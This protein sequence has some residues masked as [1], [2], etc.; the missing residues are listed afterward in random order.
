M[1]NRSDLPLSETADL[2]RLV[3]HLPGMA[4]QILADNQRTLTFAS[5]GC[6]AL[7]GYVPEQLLFNKEL[8]FGALIHPHDLQMVVQDLAVAVEAKRPYQLVYRLLTKAKAEKWVL[9]RGTPIFAADGT[10]EMIEGLIT[11]HDKRVLDFQQLE[12]RVADRTRKLSALYDILEVAAD[13]SD[14]QTTINRT[15]RRV[16][17]AIKGNVGAI[18]LIDASGKQLKLAAQ[19]N[20]V[21]AVTTKINTITVE[22]SELAGWIFRQNRPLIIPSMSEDSRTVDFVGDDSLDVY[23][24]VPIVAQ[25]QVRGV[26]TV[27]SEDMTGYAAKEEVELLVSVGEQIGVVVENARLRTSAEQLVILEERNRLARELHDSV[28]QSLYSVTLF[29]E[30]GRTLA[31]AGNL[32]KATDYFE[33]VLSTGF[34]ALREMRLLV[35]KLRPDVLEQVGIVRALEHRLNAVEGRAGVKHQL[36]VHGEIE[37]QPELEEA[38]YQITQEALNNSLK[39]SGATEIEVVLRQNQK[40]IVLLVSDNG[41]GFDVKTAVSSGGFG[42]TSMRERVNLFHGEIIVESE[43]GM[44]TAVKARVPLST[45]LPMSEALK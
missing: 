30:A 17:K 43:L 6:L 23:I 34:Q 28:T 11:D 44:G 22:K 10:L 4:F 14:L 41:C 18:H 45:P 27:L 40:S 37:L 8:A 15:L 2:A 32:E 42:L 33:D 12:Q 9:E 29:A 25:E 24:G 3:N 5:Q 21:T 38:L 19:Q 36:V 1:M 35:H 20:M 39:H 26:L 16:L 7:T 13:P 31:K